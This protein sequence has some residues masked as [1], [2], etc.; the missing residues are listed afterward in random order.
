MTPPYAWALSFLL[1]PFG[2]QQAAPVPPPGSGDLSSFELDWP[3]APV[4]HWS[5]EIAADGK[6]RYDLL[7]KGARPSAT[8]MQ[9][10]VVTPA[11]V[12][13]LRGGY[14]AVKRGSCE[15]RSK[16]LA[17]T[18]VKHIA[19]TF[20]SPDAWSSCTF[21][22]SDDKALMD[23]VATFQAIAETMQFGVTLEHQHR[24]DRLGLDATIDNLSVE[25]KDGRAIEMQNIAPVLQSIVEDDRVIERARRKA[26]RLLQPSDSPASSAQ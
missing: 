3:Q 20:G 18:G 24:Y 23:A 15:T 6:G 25:V 17:K 16:G 19:Y 11:T 5:I 8:T 10:I 4:P 2:P 1:L 7:S 14:H 22:Y 9:P 12:S 13:R 26:A 21:N